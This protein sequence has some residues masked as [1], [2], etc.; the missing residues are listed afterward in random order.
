M[1][2]DEELETDLNGPVYTLDVMKLRERL[3]VLG[4]TP[5]AARRRL[6]IAYQ[7]ANKY[8]D[9]AV[10][11]MD[12]WLTEVSA[13]GDDW[14]AD[15]DVEDVPMWA[16]WSVDPRL[17]LRL[18][19]DVAPEDCRV[20]FDIS[21]VVSRGYAE[22][23]PDLCAKAFD[24]LHGE[25]AIFSPMIVLT[26]GTTDAEFLKLGIDVIAPHLSGYVRFLDY[27]FKPEGSTSALLR[28]L[29]AFAAA[30][31]SNRV[32]A[33]FDSDTAAEEALTTLDAVKLP[34]NF[35]V[36]QLPSL[37]L[38]TD[39]PTLGPNGLSRMDVNGLAV[40]IEMF[41][42]EDV[43][44]QQGS[45]LSPVQWRGYMSK[46]QRYQGE[47]MNKPALQAAFREKAQKALARGHTLPDEDWSGMVLLLDHLKVAFH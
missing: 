37:P 25:A 27:D 39:Y 3:D 24:D 5:A 40:S 34:S 44:R 45:D 31:V 43:L 16:A 33:L 38:A 20:A 36:C 11:S 7:E 15:V 8:D 41:F 17:T 47:L 28:A 12:A 29:R 21:D 26:E 10:M 23:S 42:G 19:L 1:F 35:R 13:A 14:A 9:S 30:G 2:R 18:L 32:I 4:F 6:A 22:G 46:V